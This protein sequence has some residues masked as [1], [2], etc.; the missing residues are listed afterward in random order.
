VAA[1]VLKTLALSDPMTAFLQRTFNVR[2]EEISPLLVSALF[3]FFVLTALGA[4]RPARE[5]LGVARGMDEV[6]WLFTGTAIVTLLVTPAF[7]FL[8]SRFRRLVF[9]TASYLFFAASLLVFY[10]LL[11][12]TPEA[13]GE[14]SG[15]V[16]YVW[17]S[18]FNLFAT[19]V[20]WA[21]MADRF[22]LEQSKR[23]FAVIAAGGTI[24]AMYGPAL[25]MFLAE[26]MGTPG[27]LLVGALFLV[28]SVG[29]AWGVARLQPE[30]PEITARH[31]PSA[32]PAVDE[33]TVI[34]GSAWEG[35]RA[36]FR[37]PFLGGIG[38][39]IIILAIISTFL[40]M[41]RLQMVA[42]I[43]DSTDSRAAIFAQIDLI[44]QG[45]T[46]LLQLVIAGHLMKR[47]GVAITLAILPVTVALG[48]IGLAIVGTLT[49]LIVFEAAFRAVQ[50]A[51][52]RP[53][54]ETLFTV[55]SREDKYKSKAVIDTFGYR[56]G[57]V[58]GAWTEGLIGRLGMGLFALASVAIPL[59][60]V[61]GA[62]GIWLGR[63]QRQMAELG[64]VPARASEKSTVTS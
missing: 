8:V 14:R 63:N 23:L 2:R 9:I 32:P 37:S 49:A 5:A 27:L 34:G 45:S 36:V 64:P 12:F 51:I 15:Q 30:R 11:V 28:L 25:A 13:I 38:V 53:A 31:D 3:F 29:A 54:R 1:R 59:A 26:P 44:T 52:M 57:D 48:F 50:R 61:W 17:F 10:G 22:S 24:G 56:A 43:G 7:G 19:M 33:R 39:F 41:T 21:L 46:L 60:V 55:V 47:L 16:F 6:R 4:V 58:I 42:A 40:Y 18:V 62:I 20:F 35:I